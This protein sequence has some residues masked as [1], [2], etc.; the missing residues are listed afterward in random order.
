MTQPNAPW[1]D[2]AHYWPAGM[3][4]VAGMLADVVT[5]VRAQRRVGWDEAVA[6]LRD[7]PRQTEWLGRT[8]G[9]VAHLMPRERLA[10]Y[11]AETA[12]ET[13]L[14]STLPAEKAPVAPVATAWP[15]CPVCGSR[16]VAAGEASTAHASWVDH[17]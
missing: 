9:S 12:P 17:G 1:V 8:V 13:G 3:P 15:P 2:E 4:N 6:A 11:L 5:Y 14:R 16:V 7:G 10:R